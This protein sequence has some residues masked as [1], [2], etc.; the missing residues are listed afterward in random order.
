MDWVTCNKTKPIMYLQG[1]NRLISNKLI[2]GF[3]THTFWHYSILIL[4]PASVPG[5]TVFNDLAQSWVECTSPLSMYQREHE[6]FS[7]DILHDEITQYFGHRDPFQTFVCIYSTSTT[8]PAVHRSHALSIEWVLSAE[9]IQIHLFK[10]ICYIM[11]C[12]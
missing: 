2:S 6:K 7:R 9:L 12:I 4:P 11:L 3:I 5:A 1:T 8:L 10:K